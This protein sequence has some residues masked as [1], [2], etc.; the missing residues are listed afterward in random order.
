MDRSGTPV[1]V[2]RREGW[3]PATV[4]ERTAVDEWTVGFNDGEQVWRNHH[5]LQTDPPQVG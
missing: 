2:L 3:E 1:E 4:I 5:E